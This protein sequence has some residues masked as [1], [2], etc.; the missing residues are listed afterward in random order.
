MRDIPWWIL[1]A[2]WFVLMGCLLRERIYL[3]SRLTLATSSAAFWRNSHISNGVS[4]LLPQILLILGMYAWF[5]YNLRGLSLFGE[6]RPVLPSEESLPELFVGA[7]GK[8]IFESQDDRRSRKADGSLAGKRLFSMFSAEESGVRVERAARPLNWF[9]VWPCI[10]IVIATPLLCWLTLD[11]QVVQTLADRAFGAFVFWIICIAISMILS[12]TLRFACTWTRLRQL[13]VF[14]DR[15]RLRRTLAHLKGLSWKSVLSM[16]GNVLEERYRLVSRQLESARNL[17]TALSAW[18]P[19]DDAHKAIVQHELGECEKAAL[20][21]AED[22]AAVLTKVSPDRVAKLKRD[23]AAYQER[24][25]KTA[26]CVLT[27]II[28]PAWQHEGQSLILE[29]DSE[30]K[31]EEKG[32]PRLPLATEDHVKAAEE[33]FVLPYLGFIQNTLGAM[34]TIAFGM[35]LLFTA[36]TLALSSY[37]FSPA[38]RL[39]AIF[40]VLF[41]VVGS[42]VI[43]VY[44]QMHRDATLSHITQTEQG[45]LGFEFYSKIFSFGIGPLIGLLTTLFPA[46]TDFLVSWLQPGAE[47]MK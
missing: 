30:G 46:I 47:T 15:L 31:T 25:A 12:D 6:D 9:Y 22:Y 5:W 33:F 14:L 27:H 28:V 44:A 29:E 3:N 13:L 39:G 11:K 1:A 8:P 26:G 10:F 40:L 43:V 7:D 2:L 16:S 19:A 34:R 17:Q 23:L 42:T 35:L 21:F 20:D 41:L 45:E 36:S 18:H 24:M 37:P 4:G 38:P 32:E